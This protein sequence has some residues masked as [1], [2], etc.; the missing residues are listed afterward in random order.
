MPG[1]QQGDLK[2]VELRRRAE[3]ENVTPAFA[4]EAGLHEPGRPR[5][6]NEF[7]VAGDMVAV[8]VGDKGQG[9][10]FVRI[11]PQGV[12]GQLKP[13]VVADGNHAAMEGIFPREQLNRQSKG[14]EDSLGAKIDT[15]CLGR[16]SSTSK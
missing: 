16:L 9:T 7:R 4:T 2:I 11:E 14:T 1:G 3:L 12:L 10:W 15:D 8:R 13:S 5:T 6:G